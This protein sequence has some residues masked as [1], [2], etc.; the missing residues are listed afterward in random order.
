[1]TPYFK[2]VW[3]VTSVLEWKV[4]VHS[5][6]FRRHKDTIIFPE[7]L[8]KVTPLNLVILGY[9]GGDTGDSGDTKKISNMYHR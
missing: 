8:L 2:A 6:P 4:F 7:T 5:S 3:S 1:M 9:F